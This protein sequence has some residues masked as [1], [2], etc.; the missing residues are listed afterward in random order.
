VAHARLVLESTS[1]GVTVV[2]GGMVDEVHVK[3]ARQVLARHE[4]AQTDAQTEPEGHS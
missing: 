4:R 3:L 2:N 1:D